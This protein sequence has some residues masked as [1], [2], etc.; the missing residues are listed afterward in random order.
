MNLRES[1]VPWGNNLGYLGSVFVGQFF[2]LDW[3]PMRWKSPSRPTIWRNMCFG[4]LFPFASNRVASPS[5]G[6][7][8]LTGPRF[9]PG[10]KIYRCLG[11]QT[12]EMFDG[13]FSHQPPR[14][15]SQFP[16][17]KEELLEPRNHQNHRVVKDPWSFFQLDVQG[18]YK[19][20]DFEPLFW[21]QNI[22]RSFS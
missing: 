11:L 7:S 2:F 19:L 16:K 1:T 12:N 18:W 8:D 4:S 20:H 21:G 6:H 9:Q 17:L 3:D 15:D 22:L 5:F 14:D 13:H 10:W